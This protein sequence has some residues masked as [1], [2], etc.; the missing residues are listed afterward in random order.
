MRAQDFVDK[1]QHGDRA[2]VEAIMMMFSEWVELSGNLLI[3]RPDNRCSFP[4][5][6]R[7]WDGGANRTTFN[8]ERYRK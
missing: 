7:G 1:Y 8:P 3:K 6:V 2:G 4:T 5:H